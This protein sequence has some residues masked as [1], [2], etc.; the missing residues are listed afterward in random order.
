MI[1]C[2]YCDYDGEALIVYESDVDVACKRCWPKVEKRISARDARWEKAGHD[3][4]SD[5]C[6]CEI[7]AGAADRGQFGRITS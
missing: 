2:S 1:C 4:T 6:G 7:C 3:P 5:L